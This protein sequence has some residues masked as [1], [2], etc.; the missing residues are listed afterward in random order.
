MSPYS[1]VAYFLT[2]FRFLKKDILAALRDA[3]EIRTVRQRRVVPTPEEELEALAN[4]ATKRE[5]KALSVAVNEHVWKV[6]P[7]QQ[8]PPA[9]AVKEVIGREVGVG[10]DISHLNK[11]RQ[12]ARVEKVGQAV[13]KMKGIRSGLKPRPLDGK[14]YYRGDVTDA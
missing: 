2:P 7:P 14:P 3:K 13:L 1:L 5:R 11:R 8:P 10:A 4:P 6:L 9:A 12:R